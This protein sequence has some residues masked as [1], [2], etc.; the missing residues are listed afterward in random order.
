MGSDNTSSRPKRRRISKSASQICLVLTFFFPCVL[1]MVGMSFTNLPRSTVRGQLPFLARSGGGVENEDPRPHSKSRH[2]SRSHSNSTQGRNKNH[3]KTF[4][5]PDAV[6]DDGARCG[7]KYCPTMETVVPAHGPAAGGTTITVTGTNLGTP[8]TLHS[9][10][11]GS[12]TCRDFTSLSPTQLTCVTP[13]GTGI[14]REIAVTV[15]TLTGYSDK[16]SAQFSYDPPR[17]LRVEPNHAPRSGDT[18]VSP[19]PRSVDTTASPAPRS[20][21][22]TVSPAPRS[23]DT[24]ASPAPRSGDTTASRRAAGSWARARQARA[25]PRHAHAQA[26][27]R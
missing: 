8:E 3:Q 14:H 1:L 16:P 19:A 11:V 4:T 18:T 9:V 17:V 13:P 26:T 21:E 24:T 10:S 25:L 2:G 20:G 22:T 23:G 27:P 15:R 12:I 7:D 6:Y 5:D